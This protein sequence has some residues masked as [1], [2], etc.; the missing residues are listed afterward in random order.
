MSSYS[1]RGRSNDRG[2]RGR[3]RYTGRGRGRSNPRTSNI[4]KTQERELKFSPMNYQGKS[5][6]ATYTTTR[7]AMI[8]HI[9]KNYKGGIDVG[10]SLEDMS[11]VNLDT[12]QPA[13]IISSEADAARK[14]VDQAGL[15]IKYQEELRRHLDRKDAL[16][17]GLDKAYALILSQYCSKVMQSRI[18]QHPDFEKVL[19][20][21]PIAVLEAIKSLMH[22]CVR[23]QYP[24]ISMTDALGRL[25]N[26]KQQDNESLLDYVR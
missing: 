25:I 11:K 4:S 26:I 21:D 19:K 16:R 20:N 6:A 9:R 5:N 23:A 15:D 2:G 18:E 17:D 8:Q 3:G 1:G 24:M 7:D 10:K 12:E 14:I 22:D 13:R